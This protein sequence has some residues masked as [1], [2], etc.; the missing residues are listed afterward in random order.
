V[1]WRSVQGI[2]AAFLVPGSLAI[3][4]ASFE[5]SSRGKAIGTWSGFT[6]IT[7]ALGPV[8]GGYLIEHVSWRWVFFINLPLAALVI[9]ISLRHVPESRSAN[10]QQI[11]WLGATVG[12]LGLTGLIYGFVESAHLG[13]GSPRI[14]GSLILGLFALVLFVFIEMRVT[15]PMVPLDLF[16]RRAFAGANLLT[17]FLY[18]ALGAFFFL[19]PLN[20][21]QIQK[22][23]ATATGAAGLPMIVLMF[24]LS[25]WSGGLVARYGSK[26]PLVVGPLIAAAGF[27]LFAIPSLSSNYWNTFFPAFV[28]LGLGMAISVAP[29]TTTVMGSVEQDRA[30]T[31]SG[32][33]N[34]V[35]RVAGVLAIAVL[36]AVM[37]S[38]FAYSLRA[39]V[40]HLRLDSKTSQVLESN[41][42]KLGA[43]EVPANQDKPTKETIRTAIAQAFVVG[44][45][46]VILICAGLALLSSLVAWRMIPSRTAEMANS[47]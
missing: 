7:M 37:V 29:L 21:I 38:A 20:L 39:S 22:Y 45:R 19:F 10:S 5:E 25:R 41:V 27:L 1:I 12:T 40:G 24:S 33:N 18:S 11:D 30:G 32:I 47:A 34:A 8:L 28:V 3:I 2:A 46:I 14:I 4:S 31:A 9:V 43:L 15:A 35:A 26:L 6:A 44:F 13:W 36:G 16:K 42:N 23:S 17:L